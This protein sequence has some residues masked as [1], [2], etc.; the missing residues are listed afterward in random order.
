MEQ[1]VVIRTKTYCVLACIKVTLS[2]EY[3]NKLFGG[4]HAHIFSLPLQQP[5]WSTALINAWNK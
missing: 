1:L 3:L 4:K 2:S 5:T